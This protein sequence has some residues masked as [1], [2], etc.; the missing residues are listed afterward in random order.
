MR[1]SES[2]PARDMQI[3]TTRTCRSTAEHANHQTTMNAPS[4]RISY[5]PGPQQG[6]GVPGGGGEGGLAPHPTQTYTGRPKLKL[7]RL[8]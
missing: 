7:W 6:R 5:T 8:N 2:A 3:R 1:E 4:P